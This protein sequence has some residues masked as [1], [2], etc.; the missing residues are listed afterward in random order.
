[1]AY[2]LTYLL[3]NDID[4]FLK[5]HDCFIIHIASAGAIL[6][7][8]LAALD[9]LLIRNKSI[10][11]D[12][13][14]VFEVQINPNL[15]QLLKFKNAQEKDRYLTDFIRIAKKGIFSFDKTI[16][17]DS[18]D[19]FY[20]L[21]AWPKSPFNPHKLDELLPI[22]T[23]EYISSKIE[24][25]INELFRTFNRDSLFDKFELLKNI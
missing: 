17:E 8:E 2:E 14:S 3:T 16:V 10:V 9:Q 25:N 6:P 19:P 22:E 23:P 15:Q 13:D 24:N 5:I 7:T 18:T 12:F 20:H 11:Y 4:I 1:M 21:V